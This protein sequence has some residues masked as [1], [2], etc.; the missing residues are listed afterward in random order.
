M[1]ESSQSPGN[2]G[3]NHGEWRWIEAIPPVNRGGGD[4]GMESITRKSRGNYEEMSSECR[5]HLTRSIH[6]RFA[7]GSKSTRNFGRSGWKC[8]K[9]TFHWQESSRILCNHVTVI[10]CNKI[11]TQLGREH[12]KV[13]SS[14][15]AEMHG[16][17]ER[18]NWNVWRNV[19]WQRYP[20][21]QKSFII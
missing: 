15:N 9:L 16:C 5:V 21:N 12:C 14:R 17:L 1:M 6:A 4:D 2:W 8:T 10:L 11:Y 18:D 13:N 19:D 20:T 7:I 3:W